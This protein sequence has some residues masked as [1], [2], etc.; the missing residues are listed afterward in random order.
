MPENWIAG[1]RVPME[2]PAIAAIWLSVTVDIRSPSPVVAVTYT[3]APAHRVSRLPLK[4]PGTGRSPAKKQQR[5]VEQRQP[6][7]GQ[8]LAEQELQ[9][10]DRRG[11][12]VEDGAELLSRTTPRAVSMAGM[13]T[14]SIGITAGTIAT[15]LS[16][17]GCSGS[18]PRCRRGPPAGCRWPG[19]PPR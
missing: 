13:N 2:V 7:V 17:S 11:V 18:A 1:S 16:I 14:S 3:S 6:D 10:A 19:R 5:K 9:L 15:R 4:A 8:L 12:H